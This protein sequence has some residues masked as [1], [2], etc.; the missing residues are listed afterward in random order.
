MWPCARKKPSFKINNQSLEVGSP[1]VS[2]SLFFVPNIPSLLQELCSSP[3]C[4]ISSTAFGHQLMNVGTKAFHPRGDC[5]QRGALCAI[6]QGG[7]MPPRLCEDWGGL[8]DYK[9]TRPGTAWSC[10]AA[11]SPTVLLS[12][13]SGLIPKSLKIAT[14]IQ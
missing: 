7:K 1:Q 14:A 12:L 8:E 11:H 4:P 10:R 13:L 9:A 2:A 6:S 3:M 5:G